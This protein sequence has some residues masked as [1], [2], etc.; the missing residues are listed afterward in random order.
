[1]ATGPYW[2]CFFFVKFWWSSDIVLFTMCMIHTKHT[3]RQD[4]EW[5]ALTGLKLRI[6]SRRGSGPPA[7]SCTSGLGNIGN[8][9]DSA[10]LL[11]FRTVDSGVCAGDCGPIDTHVAWGVTHFC[12]FFVPLDFCTLTNCLYSP[13]NKTLSYERNISNPPNV[14]Q[15][16]WL[17]LR[18][19]GIG[20]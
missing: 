2:S 16:R 11:Y 5:V 13:T 10:C 18:K 6:P 14:R 8:L 12:I 3:L 19:S 20:R 9:Q 15:W 4:M 1:M 7:M 17:Y